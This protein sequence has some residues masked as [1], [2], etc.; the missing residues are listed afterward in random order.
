M[1]DLDKQEMKGKDE[2]VEIEKRIKEKILKIELEKDIVIEMKREDE[3]E[4]YVYIE[5]ELVEEM[6][7][8][9]IEMN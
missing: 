3:G 4:K 7:D 1:K 9:E 6:K 2:K 8:M 5:E